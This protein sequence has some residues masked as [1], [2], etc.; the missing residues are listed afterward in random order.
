M[1]RSAAVRRRTGLPLAA[2]RRTD[3]RGALPP[4]QM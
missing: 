3:T 4:E 1:E 2:R